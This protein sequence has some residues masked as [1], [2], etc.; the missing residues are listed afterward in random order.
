MRTTLIVIAVLLTVLVGLQLNEEGYLD[1]LYGLLDPCGMAPKA[2]QRG[3]DF[4]YIKLNG[5]MRTTQTTTQRLAITHSPPDAPSLCGGAFFFGQPSSLASA[6][7]A[8]RQVSPVTGRA[9][10]RPWLLP[11]AAADSR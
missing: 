5:S 3:D 1:P 11:W 2:N 8:P 7:G 10:R 4:N 9:G 6:I